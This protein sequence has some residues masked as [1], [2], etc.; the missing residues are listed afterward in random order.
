MVE[1]KDETPRVHKR[2]QKDKQEFVVQELRRELVDIFV[3]FMR[4][5]MALKMDLEKDHL[6]KQT[7]RRHF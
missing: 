5:C 3:D 6:N 4:A 1:E 2:Y 7:K